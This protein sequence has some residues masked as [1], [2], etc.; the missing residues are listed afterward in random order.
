[1]VRQLKVECLVFFDVLGF[2][3]REVDEIV[4]LRGLRIKYGGGSFIC[5][6]CFKRREEYRVSIEI[7]LFIF[8]DFGEFYCGKVIIF[9]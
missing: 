7:S 2:C 9:Y 1:M 5:Q 3:Y 6:Y 4:L 8:K